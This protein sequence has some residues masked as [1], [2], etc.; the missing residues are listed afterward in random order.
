[1]SPQADLLA[2][3]LTDPPAFLPHSHPPPSCYLYQAD[4]SFPVD[5]TDS[6][7][8]SEWLTQWARLKPYKS[9]RGLR[10]RVGLMLSGGVTVPLPSLCR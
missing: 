8:S 4:P 5:A 3:G 2:Q 1:M 9:A 7:P 10:E 6:S